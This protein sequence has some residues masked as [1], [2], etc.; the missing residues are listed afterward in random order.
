M[1]D[2]AARVTYKDCNESAALNVPGAIRVNALWLI[3]LGNVET[4]LLV[5]HTRTVAAIPA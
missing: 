3:S 1:P 5:T 2:N 4:R